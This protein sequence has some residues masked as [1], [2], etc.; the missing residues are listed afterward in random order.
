MI[1]EVQMNDRRKKGMADLL[2]SVLSERGW[3]AQLALHSIFLHWR[4]AVDISISSHTE[5]LK[6][7]KGT[8]WVEVENSAWMQQLQYEKKAVLASV[9]EFLGGEKKIRNIRFVQPQPE[10]QSAKR[11]PKVQ[12][13]APPPEELHRFQEQA[14]S[15]GDEAAR[16][17]LIRFWYLA[18]ACVREE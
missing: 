13:V 18:R 8:L 7:V 14:G 11:E 15:I 6:I 10:R 3:Q 12:F 17:A 4:D 9:N 16:E 2:P 1:K 5:P